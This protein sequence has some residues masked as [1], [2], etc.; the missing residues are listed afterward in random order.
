MKK[1]YS[2]RNVF[3]W[4]WGG[5]AV[6]MVV[7]LFSQ[8]LVAG[9]MTIFM[10]ALINSGWEQ[11][12]LTG[13]GLYLIGTPIFYIWIKKLPDSPKEQP[14]KMPISEFIL[15]FI[16]CLGLTYIFNMLGTFI[17][18]AIANIMKKSVIN[19]IDAT[20]NSQST[21][22]TFLFACIL[23]PIIE[24][25]IFRHFCLNK[26]RK[27]GDKIAIV[28]TAV[29]F[30]LFHGNLSQFF[31]AVALGILFA[32]VAVRTNSIRYTILLH[33]IINL[34]GSLLMPSMILSRN[35]FFVLVA[36]FLVYG[37]IIASVIL[38][39]VFRKKIILDE[40]Q[41][42]IPKTEQFKTIY[43]NIGMLVYFIITG[44]MIVLTILA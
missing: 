42:Q 38:L 4:L 44:G 2:T 1:E 27:Y 26:I 34:C 33:M 10:P 41:E 31:Y 22:A 3:S 7:I 29:A 32:Y 40:G 12:L 9:F 18:M 43:F 11:W 19:P 16:I 5:L 36:T 30:G 14:R 23:S 35:L 6:M 17:N 13:I 39:I 20:V 37:S 8:I 15:I 21:L 25:I 28:V 24:E